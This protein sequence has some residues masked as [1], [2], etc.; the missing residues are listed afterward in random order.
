M[1]PAGDHRLTQP[2]LTGERYRPRAH[3][4]VLIR[5]D[6]TL[7]FDTLRGVY[8]TLNRVGAEVWTFVEWGVPRTT[9]V[10][11]LRT[12]YG[13]PAERLDADVAALVERLLA[14]DLIERDG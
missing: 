4:V 13:V 12:V 11:R 8:Y 2:D 9:M 1:T 10:Q 5:G 3:V 6:R 14:A 7:L